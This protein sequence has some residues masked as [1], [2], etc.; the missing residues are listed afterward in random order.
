MIPYDGY[1]YG[2]SYY[3]TY[4]VMD[5]AK[6][7]SELCECWSKQPPNI[8]FNISN[9]M[10]IRISCVVKDPLCRKEF[11][12]TEREIQEKFENFYKGKK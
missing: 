7:N 9:G 2:R 11:L 6:N 8:D 4:S 1:G 3:W 12:R 5:A 10:K